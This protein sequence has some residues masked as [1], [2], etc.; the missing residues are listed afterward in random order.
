[1]RP[2][3][4]PRAGLSSV[5]AD[6]T[7][8]RSCTGKAPGSG[9]TIAICSEDGSIGRS[10]ASRRDR[11]NLPTGIC[12]G[13]SMGCRWSSPARTGRCAIRWQ[14]RVTDNRLI[15]LELTACWGKI[16]GPWLAAPSPYPANPKNSRR[17]WSILQESEL[18]AWYDQT[19]SR[20]SMQMFPGD[21]FFN[22]KESNGILDVISR[23]MKEMT[24][25]TKRADTS[26]HV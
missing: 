25:K 12:A 5:I 3:P 8:S 18:T 14:D 11:W 6:G 22:G 19:R 1:M 4:F 17:F 9:C 20:F 21:H 26:I 10:L 23:G 16:H 13:C 2:I 15:L 24:G 7:K